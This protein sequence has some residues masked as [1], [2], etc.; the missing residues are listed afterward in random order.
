MIINKSIILGFL[1]FSIIL[2]VLDVIW[3]STATKYIYKPNLPGLLLDKPIMWAAIL[4]YLIYSIGATLI[5]I[6]PALVDNSISYAFWTGLVFGLVAYS[7][8]S[9]TNMAVLKGWSPIVTLIDI[10]WGSFITSI[11]AALSVYFVNKII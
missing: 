10:S 1:F 6:R 7:T 11:S 2:L 8:W 4:F 9:L 3:L 5:I